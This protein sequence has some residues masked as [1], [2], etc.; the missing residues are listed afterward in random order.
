[1]DANYSNYSSNNA[2]SVYMFNNPNHNATRVI[3]N[4]WRSE[5]ATKQ[6]V[7]ISNVNYSLVTKEEILKL[8]E[9]QFDAADVPKIVRDKYYKLWDD[10]LKTL[11]QR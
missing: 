3:F 11:I 2:P 1:M 4:T 8:S 6:G 10:Y 7:S 9:R 5:I